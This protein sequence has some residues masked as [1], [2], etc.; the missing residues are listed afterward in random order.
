MEVSAGTTA[1]AGSP[2]YFEPGSPRRGRD[3]FTGKRCIACHAIA[4]AG[5]RGGPDLGSGGKD[6]VES[7][8]AIAGQWAAAPVLKGGEAP[9]LATRRREA[10]AGFRRMDGR[11]K[12]L[13]I[14]VVNHSSAR[15][16]DAGVLLFFSGH[17]PPEISQLR[18]GQEKV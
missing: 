1:S 15:V 10:M 11:T 9:W 5:G 3:L 18:L 14:K 13:V 4:G 8:P 12:R 7:V 16:Q 17:F 6:L 2:A